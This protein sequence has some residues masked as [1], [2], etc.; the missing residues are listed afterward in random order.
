MPKKA[1]NKMKDDHK[2]KTKEQLIEE[3][4]VLKKRIDGQKQI[5]TAYKMA[6]EASAESERKY[7]EFVVDITERKKID[8]LLDK[9]NQCFLSFGPDAEN[10]ISKIIKVA[11]IIFKGAC[12]LYNKENGALLCTRSEWNWN[13]PKDLGKKDNKEGYICY[14]VISKHSEKPFIIND[15]DKTVYAKTDPNVSK[16]KLKAYFGCAVKVKGKVLGSL[17][18][19]FQ[20]NRVFNQDE[21]RI[22]SILARTLGVEEERKITEDKIR[23]YKFMVESAYDAIFFKDMESRYIIANDKTLSVF[24]LPREQVIGKNDYEIMPDKE[25]ARKNIEDDRFVFKTGEQKEIIKHMTGADGKKYW[26]QAIKVPQLDDKGNIVG[27]VGIGRDITEYKKAEKMLKK[28]T[29]ALVRKAIALREVVAEVEAEKN[30]IKE[31]MAAKIKELVM[32]ILKKLSMKGSSEKYVD[33]LY[34]QLDNLTSSLG[35]KLTKK[36]TKL[37]PREIEICRMIEGG[38]S[39]KEVSQLLYLSTQTVEKHRKNIRKKLGMSDKS[40]NLASYL[41]QMD[42]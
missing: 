35:Y 32:P 25:E 21:V 38:L 19:V 20:E 1:K 14:D 4:E 3:L 26:F 9:V 39:S 2:N 41:L 42:Q 8:M 16:Y 22:L 31:D 27:L 6:K 24:G 30:K 13:S 17:C 18:I 11:G 15:L 28:Q 34:H 7:R 10:N 12:A 40:I 23:Q 33:L 36:S 5:K 37:T 29:L